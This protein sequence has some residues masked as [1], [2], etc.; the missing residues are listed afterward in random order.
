MSKSHSSMLIPKV[1]DLHPHSPLGAVISNF[2]ILFALLAPFLIDRGSRILQLRPS[3]FYFLGFELVLREIPS[4]GEALDKVL[5]EIVWNV[6]PLRVVYEKVPDNDHVV[7]ILG[8]FRG[9][10]HFG[11][12]L[13]GFFD[14]CS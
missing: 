10:R 5:L 11:L 8:V 7:S 6:L 14:C 1:Q 2:L 13:Q 4:F 12:G 3:L 9:H